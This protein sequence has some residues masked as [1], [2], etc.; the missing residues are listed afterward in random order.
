MITQEEEAKY[1]AAAGEP[2]GSLA[3]VLVDTGLRPE[4]CFRL[5]WE[6]IS[7]SGG[8]YGTLRTRQPLLIETLPVS[9]SLSG[10]SK[11]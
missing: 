1:L 10:L 11:R 8:R 4:E 3:T 2:L 5:R 7:F 6:D 9:A